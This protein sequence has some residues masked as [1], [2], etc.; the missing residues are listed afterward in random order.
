MAVYKSRL[1]SQSWAGETIGIIVLECYYPFLPGNVAN[2][3]TYTF[4]VRYALAEGVTG[5][6]L[7]YGSTESLLEPFIAAA[8]KLEAEGVKAI[9]GACGFMALFQK[10]IAASVNIPVFVSSLLQVNFMHQITNK[11]VG[12]ICADSTCL[13]PEH[14]AGTGVSTSVPLAITGMEGCEAFNQGIRANIG[15]LDDEGIRTGIVSVAQ[16]LVSQYPDV[17]SIL[18]ECSD[19]PPY[20]HAVQEATGLPVFDFITMINHVHESLSRTRYTGVI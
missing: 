17:G 10:E 14:L 20:A 5:E 12:I 6:K 18:L 7:L 16:D 13:K 1:R 19:L 2:A 11:R 8:H 3:S 9:T 15:E 4:P